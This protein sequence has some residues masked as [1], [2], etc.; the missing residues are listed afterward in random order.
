MV[1]RGIES[2]LEEHAQ[3]L[4]RRTSPPPPLCEPAIHL[5][6]AAQRW[7]IRYDTDQ[8]YTSYPVPVIIRDPANPKGRLGRLP[9]DLMGSELFGHA[10]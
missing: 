5:A 9:C 6:A 4:E 7:Q 10:S 3:Q 1:K 8:R 2:I